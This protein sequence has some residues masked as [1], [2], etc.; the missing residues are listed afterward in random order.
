MLV[1]AAVDLLATQ[2]FEPLEVADLLRD[3][4]AGATSALQLVG[5]SPL[6]P[7]PDYPFDAAAA[8]VLHEKAFPILEQLAHGRLPLDDLAMVV[9]EELIAEA[10]A[11]A[12]ELGLS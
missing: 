4:W 6:P 3:A 9:L 11:R 12:R 1:G 8:M 5:C 2:F 10:V 7:P